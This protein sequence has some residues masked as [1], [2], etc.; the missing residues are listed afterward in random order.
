MGVEAALGPASAVG[1]TLYGWPNEVCVA[2][3]EKDSDLR[4]LDRELDR[5]SAGAG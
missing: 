2:G 3:A 4:A 1:E 5:R